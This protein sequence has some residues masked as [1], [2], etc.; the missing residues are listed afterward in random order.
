MKLTGEIDRA[1]G[2]LDVIPQRHQPI[3]RTAGSGL[4][5]TASTTV[6]TVVAAGAEAE[7]ETGSANG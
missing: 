5:T 7:N 6:N 1:P 4:R 2:L 3:G